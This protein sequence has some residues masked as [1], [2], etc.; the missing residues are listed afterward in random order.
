MVD[1]Y[2][3]E[4]AGPAVTSTRVEPLFTFPTLAHIEITYACME[5]CVMCYNPTRAKVTDRD[6]ALVWDVVRS[7]GASRIPHTYLI[8]GEPT[9]GYRKSELE[10][11]VDYLSDCGSSVTIVTNGQIYLKGMTD[12]LA[13]YGVSLHAAEPGMHDAITQT[14]GS[15]N[16]AVRTAREYVQEGHDVRIIPVV[17]GMNHD[18]MYRIAELAWNIG[19]E[20]VYYDVYEPGGIGEIN[21]GDVSLRMQPTTHE[22]STAVGQIV[23]AHDDFPFRGSVGFGTALPYCFDARLVERNMLANCG[24]GTY[25]CAITNTGDMRLCNQSKMVFGNVLQ[26]P[27]E[28]I[29]MDP[30]VERLYRSLRIVC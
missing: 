18:Q 27:L 14:P 10:D 12:R 9:Y 16:K 20:S 15:W 26:R 1:P 30:D 6:K 13:C 4:R 23:Q 28:D 19:A 21:S 7:I 17:M 11:Y 8:G 24:V 22:L 2:L 25:F 29:W 3:I 5:D